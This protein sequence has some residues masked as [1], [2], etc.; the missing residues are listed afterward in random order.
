MEFELLKKAADQEREDI[1]MP[2]LLR[3]VSRDVAQEE[4]R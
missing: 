4:K 3:I 1:P 2:D